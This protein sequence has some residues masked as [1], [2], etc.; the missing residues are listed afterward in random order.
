MRAAPLLFFL[1]P[2]GVRAQAP[3]AA[4]PAAPAAAVAGSTEDVVGHGLKVAGGEA[5]VAVKGKSIAVRI[6]KEAV[7]WEPVS[8][9]VIGDA[10]INENSVTRKVPGARGK[11]HKS[12]AKAVARLHPYKGDK[13][14]V[15]S[16]YPASFKKSS[17]HLE[18]R[19]Q[20]IEGYL[21]GASI[22]AITL[23]AGQQPVAYGAEDSFTL[24]RR[25][26]EFA[27]DFPAEAALKISAIDSKPGKTSRNAGSVSG[28]DFGG[29]E[30]GTISFFYG[31]QGVAG[32]RAAPP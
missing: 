20:I 4:P 16:L 23:K 27:E 7:D 1:L 14:L 19:L 21:E 2:M 8:V 29:K 26:L 13:M 32:G 15:V 12:A 11:G 10:G 5:P 18:V 9:V 3:D 6:H 24:G 25:G 31:T 30:L 22:A 28:A 17:V